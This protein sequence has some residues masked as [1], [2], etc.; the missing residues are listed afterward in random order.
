MSRTTVGVVLLMLLLTGSIL[1]AFGMDRHNEDIA[2]GLETAAEQA[3]AGDM[4][5]AGETARAA[6]KNWESGWNVC[7]AF[8]DHSPMEQID[9]GFAR[10]HLYERLQDPVAFAS[11]C[12]ELAK[13]VQAIGDAHGAQWW[14]IL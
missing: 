8:T 11:V 10:L 4:D 6:W 7:A 14:N 3:L 9:G 5:L 12:V 1:S 13:Q 2:S